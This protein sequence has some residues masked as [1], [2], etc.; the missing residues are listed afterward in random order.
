MSSRDRRDALLA[1]LLAPACAACDEP[2]DEPTRGP[3]CAAAGRRSL[4]FTPPALRARAA[5]RC[6]RGERISVACRP[7]SALPPARPSAD[8][9][10][11][12]DR[13]LRRRPA[14]DRPRAEVR[15]PPIAR[16]AAGALMAQH[17]ARASSTERTSSCRFRCTVAAARARLQSGGGARAAS[18]GSRPLTRCGACARRRH[19]PT[20]RPRSA[21]RTCSDAFALAAARRRASAR[22]V[23]L[24]DDVSTTGATLD[25]CARVLLEAGAREVRALTAARVVARPR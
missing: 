10:A 2:L 3:V 23:V 1:V 20:C 11:A 6:R 15:R 19:R 7:V 22:V 24:V 13:R 14:R 9:A 21:T 17:G 5:I 8:H 4:P 12:G 18:A 16:A 25:A